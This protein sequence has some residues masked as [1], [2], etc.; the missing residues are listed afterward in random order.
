M[1][2]GLQGT[3]DPVGWTALG[4]IVILVLFVADAPFKTFGQHYLVA[5]SRERLWLGLA[6]VG[7]A[8]LWGIARFRLDWDR[9]ILPA[10][11]RGAGGERWLALVGL[12]VVLFG[13]GLA[14]WGKLRLGR[15]FTG[16]FAIKAGHEL[17][18]DGP[19]AV[20]RHPM[21]TGLLAAVTGSALVFDSL[22]TLLL[23]VALMVP[24]YLHTLIEEE[25]FERHF[26]DA[27][28]RYRARVPRFVP[29]T[30]R[31]GK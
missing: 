31:G 12:A 26:G 27:W 22:L 24:F 18:T 28:R 13:V 3:T 1:D 8:I 29:F 10:A 23:A 16:T 19:Y 5:R 6:E 9:A 25:L 30:R 14:V 20:T 2:N 11:A 17:V 15:W 7:L 4:A 21:Y